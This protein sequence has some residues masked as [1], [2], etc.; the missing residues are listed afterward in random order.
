M[1]FEYYEFNET[2]LWSSKMATER[3]DFLRQDIKINQRCWMVGEECYVDTD[4]AADEPRG[5]SR[6]D[7]SPACE[8]QQRAVAAETRQR[9]WIMFVDV[10]ASWCEV[11]A[12]TTRPVCDDSLSSAGIPFNRLGYVVSKYVE[13]PEKP[14]ETWAAAKSNNLFCLTRSVCGKVDRPELK[15]PP[16]IWLNAQ[17]VDQETPTLFPLTQ[18]EKANLSWMFIYLISAC[19]TSHFGSKHH[20][21]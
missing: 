8:E 2:I 3:H 11:S 14:E 1:V 12:L 19:T 16:C 21:Q 13:T 10:T 4:M 18:T 20:K 9:T 15:G 5:C 6:D 7:G 17:C